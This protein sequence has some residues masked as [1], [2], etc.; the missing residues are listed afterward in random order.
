V[1]GGEFYKI[2][3]VDDFAGFRRFIS[4]ALQ[5]K[6]GFQIVQAVD[7]LEAVQKAEE[8][9]PDLILLDIGLPILNGLEAARQILEF[10]SSAKI[11]FLS[12]ESCADVIREALDLGARGYVHKS[13]AQGDLLPAVEAVLEGK[14]FVSGS[15]RFEARKSLNHR[16]EIFFCADDATLLEALAVF[17]AGTLNVGDPAIVW[18]TAEHRE[19]LR[20][21]LYEMGIDADAAVQCGTFIAADVSEP[22]DPERIL[23]AIEGLSEAAYRMGKKRPRVSVCGERAGLYWGEGKADAALRLEQALNEL[24][25]SNELEI[26]CVYP[27]PRGQAEEAFKSVCAE[28][29]A[30][31]YQ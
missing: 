14:E 6:P 12:Q 22:P 17:L 20:E 26:L 25:E 28:H 4:C 3:V 11:L 10:D 8:L 27:L 30:V 18:A 5:Q 13:A 9:K 16:H 23:A 29:T 21:R 7:G 19:G 15:L 24:A 31:R 1:S 2:L